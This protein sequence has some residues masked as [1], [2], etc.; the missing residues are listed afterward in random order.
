MSWKLT[1]SE[2]KSDQIKQIER[3]IVQS[4]PTLLVLPL[5]AKQQTPH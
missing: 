3:M 2:T 1:T 4:T 5:T